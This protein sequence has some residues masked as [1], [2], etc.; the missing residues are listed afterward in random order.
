[1]AKDPNFGE[2]SGRTIEHRRFSLHNYR[3]Q[4]VPRDNK[5]TKVR[6]SKELFKRAATNALRHFVFTDEKLCTVVA[7][8]NSTSVAYLQ[9]SSKY[10]FLRT[11]RWK[12]D[13]CGQQYVR[14][15]RR[16]RRLLKSGSLKGYISAEEWHPYRP[17]LNYLFLNPLDYSV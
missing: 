6:T 5:Q 8:F 3:Q 11:A 10:Q 1:M 15:L 12:E 4:K 13:A 9:I 14:L 2:G 16:S 17:D 7:E